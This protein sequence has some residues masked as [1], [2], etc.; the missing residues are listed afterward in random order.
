MSYLTLQDILHITV[1]LPI[2][3]WALY[4]PESSATRSSLWKTRKCLSHPES[5]LTVFI[6]FPIVSHQRILMQMQSSDDG[7]VVSTYH[8]SALLS[9]V[10]VLP[11]T[12]ISDTTDFSL[13]EL[14]QKKT[15]DWLTLE[16]K[17]NNTK[18][19]IL[20]I[21]LHLLTNGPRTEGAA[22]TGHTE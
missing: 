6:V 2:G 4:Q 10:S 12:W 20:W 9:G 18:N 16:E 1:N 22:I 13:I 19:I 21:L 17:R 7:T 5:W 14:G 15:Y 3:N 8:T 11:Q